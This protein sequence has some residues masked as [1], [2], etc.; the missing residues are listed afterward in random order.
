[1]RVGAHGDHDVLWY[2]AITG[3]TVVRS[4]AQ[5]RG[6]ARRRRLV[7]RPRRVDHPRRALPAPRGRRH[8]HRHRQPR[9]LARLPRGHRTARR[10]R[11]RRRARVLLPHVPGVHDRRGAAPLADRDGVR[12]PG[13]PGRSD[14]LHPLLRARP[15]RDVTATRGLSRLTDVVDG[16]DL[17]A[18]LGLAL[19]GAAQATL[20][21]A[22]QRECRQGGPRIRQQREREPRVVAQGEQPVGRQ[23]EA[24]AAAG[25]VSSRAPSAANG[26]HRARNASYPAARPSRS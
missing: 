14:D 12:R 17:Q 20:E 24:R 3:G 11:G 26:C 19:G 4:A 9:L 7:P 16:Q 6:P 10:G 21:R 23:Q 15:D 25:R 5:R 2:V 13:P 8:R 18:A 1:M 22:V